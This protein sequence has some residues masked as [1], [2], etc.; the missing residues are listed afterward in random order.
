MLLLLTTT[1]RYPVDS[2]RRHRAA[3][4]YGPA[5]PSVVVVAVASAPSSSFVVIAMG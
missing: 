1:E 4:D 5:H 3:V 2:C